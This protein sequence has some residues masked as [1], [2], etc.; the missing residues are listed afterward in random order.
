MNNNAPLT[1]PATENDIQPTLPVPT[2]PPAQVPAASS[3]SAPEPPRQPPTAYRQLFPSLVE[4]SVQGNYAEIIKVAERGDLNVRNCPST[5]LLHY[6]DLE[7]A[8][9]L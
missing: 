3:S 7:M 4:L 8:G 9:R 1:P 6:S 2:D 5:C